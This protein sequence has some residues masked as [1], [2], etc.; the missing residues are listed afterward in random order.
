M[1]ASRTDDLKAHAGDAAWHSAALP[2]VFLASAPVSAP[3]RGHLSDRAGRRAAL[4]AGSAG[5][6]LAVV[7]LLLRLVLLPRLPAR[8]PQVQPVRVQT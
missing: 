6:A 8:L 3:L 1:I 2:A 4:L 5:S 7:P